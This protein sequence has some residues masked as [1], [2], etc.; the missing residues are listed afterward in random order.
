[1]ADTRAM[2]K[3]N[4]NLLWLLDV[5]KP[6]RQL[7]ATA[8]LKFWQYGGHAGMFK[9]NLLLFWTLCHRHFEF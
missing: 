6:S 9:P 8:I 7:V 2:F 5:N 1:M 4:F 3:P